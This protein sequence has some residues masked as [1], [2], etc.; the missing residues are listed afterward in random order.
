MLYPARHAVGQPLTGIVLTIGV[1]S[2][3]DVASARA[4]LRSL[5]PDAPSPIPSLF[6]TTW[7]T[8]G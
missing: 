3:A 4:A 1:T 6:G 7:G 8:A 5:C 2:I